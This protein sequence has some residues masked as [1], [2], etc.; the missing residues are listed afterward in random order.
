MDNSTSAPARSPR[1]SL[2]AAV[3]PSP[4]VCHEVASRA[5]DEL[6]MNRFL[7]ACVLGSTAF[8]L[9]MHDISDFPPRPVPARVCDW[10]L[11]PQTDSG[12][13]YSGGGL[14]C[15][16]N[17]SGPPC[18][19]HVHLPLTWNHAVHWMKPTGM[20]RGPRMKKYYSAIDSR[21]MG[22][23]C[24]SCPANDAIHYQTEDAL[25]GCSP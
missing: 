25:V 15:S 24:D 21:C 7:A 11:L 1:T 23:T 4:G 20:T 6:N 2:Q 5:R 10:V 16:G 13:C 19:G 18:C 12:G 17:G 3:A 22:S 9:G 14:D 8:L